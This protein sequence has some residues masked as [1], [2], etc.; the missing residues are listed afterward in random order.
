LVAVRDDGGGCAVTLS[1]RWRYL[2]VR[3]V[4]GVGQWARRCQ[5]RAAVTTR[6]VDDATRGEG[7]TTMTSCKSGP[8][9]TQGNSDGGNDGSGER[10]T[11]R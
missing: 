10:W 8:W 2:G 1:G 3:A 11:E 4:A 7:R 6:T 5:R 9:K